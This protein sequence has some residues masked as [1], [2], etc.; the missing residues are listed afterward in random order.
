MSRKMQIR[1]PSELAEHISPGSPLSSAS[2]LELNTLP[3]T[4]LRIKVPPGFWKKYEQYRMSQRAPSEG[5]PPKRQ[6][7]T[8]IPESEPM[9]S[10]A[11]PERAAAAQKP[12][13]RP[14]QQPGQGPTQ[15]P[16]QGP[17]EGAP[18]R[19]KIMN[20]DSES[21]EGILYSD[22]SSDSD[23]SI[24]STGDIPYSKPDIPHAAAVAPPTITSTPDATQSMPPSSEKPSPRV[25]SSS[26]PA[27]DSKPTVLVTVAGGGPGHFP[28]I[29]V[30]PNSQLAASLRG[31]PCTRP[32][33]WRN[34]VPRELRNQ[35]TRDASIYF[36][37]GELAP[38]P[39]T[40]CVRGKGPFEQ[41]V[42]FPNPTGQ[43]PLRGACASC[44]WTGNPRTCSFHPDHLLPGM[45]NSTPS[46][47]V[48]RKP[49]IVPRTPRTPNTPA[50]SA[51]P[52]SSAK[53]LPSSVKPPRL[54]PFNGNVTTPKNILPVSPALSMPPS[55]APS[56][57]NPVASSPLPPP[58]QRANPFPDHVYFNIPDKLNGGNLTEV[59]KAIQEMDAV[60][61]KL[62]ERANF[63]EQLGNNWQ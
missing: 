48:D 21:K 18:R 23:S 55:I 19:P 56:P 25:K 12:A 37:R 47:L 3:D 51:K 32:I 35:W 17:T 34:G 61:S 63:L 28:V 62:K 59:R 58:A 27:P 8:P 57:T 14:S 24:V 31:T 53:I 2:S 22:A 52:P 30:I 6:K 60:L 29:Q 26:T 11:R 13:Q 45:S 15:R 50:S 40:S 42:R 9:E 20:L 1:S 54:V 43:P 33:V 36:S 41:C 16:T 49:S 39:C 7:I 46:K 5:P 4:P 38:E 10:D 44:I